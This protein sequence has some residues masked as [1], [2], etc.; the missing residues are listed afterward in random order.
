MLTL[1]L[2]ENELQDL[3]ELIYQNT[4]R[5]NNM[6]DTIKN[7]A[8]KWKN[9]NPNNESEIVEQILENINI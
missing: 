1:I 8:A 4:D 3:L 5:V 2:K 6:T 9:N 7:M